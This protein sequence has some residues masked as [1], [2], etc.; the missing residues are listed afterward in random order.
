MGKNLFNLCLV[1]LVTFTLTIPNVRAAANFN[2]VGTT[3]RAAEEINYLA[4]LGIVLGDQNYFYPDKYITRAET[5][6]IIGRALKLE[7]EKTPTRFSDVGAMMFA[8]GYIAELD[9]LGIISGY[10]NGTFKPYEHINRG[11]VAV[12]LSK[13][14]QLGT[15]QT[16]SEAIKLLK[17]NEIAEGKPDGTFGEQEL[18]KRSD[19]AV[20]IA[21]LLK[22]GYSSV[23]TSKDL[24]F[25]SSQTIVI[26]PGHGGTDPGA[27]GYNGLKEKDVVFDVSKKV[28][29]LFKETPFKVKMTRTTDVKIELAERVRLADEFDGD[30]FVS[31][32]ANAFNGSANGTETYYY[33]AAPTNPYTED[34][35]LLAEKLQNRLLEELQL[36]NRGVKTANFYVIKYNTMPAALAELGFID[37]ENEGKLLALDSFRTKAAKAIYLGILDYYETKGIDVAYYK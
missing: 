13:A 33:A 17:E 6:A 24:E 2:D 31:I 1:F 5:S 26:D 11:E 34:S 25:I 27:V 32:H 21:K 22:K 19:L 9:R 35:K 29:A 4:A 7:G 28:E 12:L 18:I 3:H 8:S 36:K 16:R 37:N 30:V 15:F 14:F 20:F 23:S 10:S